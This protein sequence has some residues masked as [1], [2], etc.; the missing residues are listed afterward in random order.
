MVAVVVII[1]GAI[2]ARVSLRNIRGEQ[3]K[4]DAEAAAADE[5]AQASV[6]GTDASAGVA[7]G[8]AP[9]STYST[10]SDVRDT[11]AALSAA[12]ERT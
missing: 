7:S 6:A 10:S 5:E 2:T 1:G 4:A 8:L 11:T 9:D 3:D 12:A